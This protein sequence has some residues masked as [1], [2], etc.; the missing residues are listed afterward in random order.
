MSLVTIWADKKTLLLDYQLFFCA[1][2][3]K[4]GL[5]P[6]YCIHNHKATCMPPVTRARNWQHAAQVPPL[7]TRRRQTLTSRQTATTR[8]SVPDDNYTTIHARR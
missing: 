1:S 6:S 5:S 7:A 8:Q 3:S 2:R 4:D